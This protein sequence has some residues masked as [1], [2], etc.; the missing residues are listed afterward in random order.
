M[1]YLQLFFE[2][3][4]TGLFAIGGGQATIPFLYDIGVKTNWYSVEELVN[5][6]AIS[7]S[8]PGPIGVNMATYVGYTTKGFLGSLCSTLGVITPSIIIITLIAILLMG[9]ASKPFV[10]EVFKYLRAAAIGMIGYAV[11]Q[12]ATITLVNEGKIAVVNCVFCILLLVLMRIFKKVHPLF[13]ILA[14]AV[15]GILFI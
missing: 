9:F 11:Y 14:G 15:F 8:T 4:K 7:E 6:I 13:F 5:M 10:K 3:F 12:V 2:F 1:I